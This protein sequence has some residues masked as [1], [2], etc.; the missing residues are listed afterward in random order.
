ML[1][2]SGRWNQTSPSIS[3]SSHRAKA[4]NGC[5]LNR[6]MSASLPTS[7]EPRRCSSPSSRAGLIVIIASACA[8][9]TPPYLTILAASR[10]RW[11]ISSSL[12]LLMQTETPAW[13]SN[14][15]L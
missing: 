7:I 15:A 11:R 3:A 9:V 4:S 10:L 12:S 8:S 14:A 6:T 5:A 13:V 1:S 2:F